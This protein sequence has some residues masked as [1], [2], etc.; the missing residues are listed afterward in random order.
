[1]KLSL[2]IGICDRRP[3]DLGLALLSEGLAKLHPT[4]EP[5]RVANGE[6]LAAAEAAAREKRL[7]VC[8]R[9]RVCTA[10][11]FCA[12]TSKYCPTLALSE[13]TDECCVS[14]GTWLWASQSLDPFHLVAYV[15]ELSPC[16]SSVVASA[17]MGEVRRAGGG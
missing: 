13:C 3:V 5:Q 9:H 17:G 8:F 6:Q 11:L 1:M 10:A 4:F 16:L 14:V 7:K 2:S 12:R 15:W